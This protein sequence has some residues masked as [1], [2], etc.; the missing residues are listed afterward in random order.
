[1]RD[2]DVR[3]ITKAMSTMGGCPVSF[4][5]EK[6]SLREAHIVDQNLVN[7]WL[8]TKSLQRRPPEQQFGIACLEGSVLIGGVLNPYSSRMR[9]PVV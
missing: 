5:V 2:V 6:P 8:L 1:M 4:D 3:R 9:S 7:R